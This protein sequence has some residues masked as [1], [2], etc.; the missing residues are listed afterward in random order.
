MANDRFEL[1]QAIMNAWHT[2]DDIGLLADAVIEDTVDVDEL[3]NV[4]LGLQQLHMMRAKKAFD[5]FEAMI[6]A[7]DIK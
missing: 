1:E 2:A 7:G 5:I 4:L 6:E 3:S